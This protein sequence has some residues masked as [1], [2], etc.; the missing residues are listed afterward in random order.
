MHVTVFKAIFYNMIKI[1]NLCVK[2]KT[3]TILNDISLEILPGSTMGLV[4]ESGSG[5]TTLGRSI[6]LLN[7]ISS[8]HVYYKDTELTPSN[9]SKY[10]ADMQMVF[11]DPYASID[12]KMKTSK[13]I[14]EPLLITG[15]ITS[16]AMIKSKVDDLLCLVGL[17]PAHGNKLIHEFSG[18]QRQRIAIAR[19]LAT[20]PEFIIWDESVS[21][22]DVSVKAQIINLISRLQKELGLTYLFISH[23]LP[24]VRHLCDDIAVL[25]HGKIVEKG[26][27]DKVCFNPEHEYTK[28]L[29][30]SVLTRKKTH[31]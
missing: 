7:K 27:C 1:K 9:I 10:R 12:P 31:T 6:L 28:R 14:A 20:S 19:A 24:V 17:S 16:P 5:K 13:V 4:G 22:L 15:K 18:G 26:R 29:V 11:Q 21:A 23:D 8:G 30:A 3:L 2:F 25:E